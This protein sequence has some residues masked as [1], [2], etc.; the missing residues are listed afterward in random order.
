MKKIQ[1]K[2]LGGWLPENKELQ[3]KWVNDLLNIVNGTAKNASRETME[4]T[5]Q[6]RSAET[7]YVFKH[8]EVIDFLELI[9]TDPKL[10]LLAEQMIDQAL[11]YDE[12]DPT[13]SPQITSYNLMLRII[14]HII[15]TAPEYVP[16]EEKEKRALIGF[17]INA[18]LDWCMGTQAGYAFFLDERVNEHFEKILKA[19]C[20]YLSSKESAYVL[21]KN[22]ENGGWLCDKA[23]LELGMDQYQCD[24]SKDYY[25]FESWNDFF[26]RKFKPDSR[27]IAEADK[28]P[29]VI[30]NA[31]ESQPYKISTN[32]Q[33]DTKFWLKGQPYSLEYMLNHDESADLFVGGTVYQA[34]LSATRYHRWHSPVD[35]KVVRCFNVPGTYYAEVNTYP[36]DGA[37]PNNSQ[38]YITHVAARAVILIESDNK[39]IGLM[40]FIAV[41]MAEVS[42]C[43]IGVKEGQ[44]LNK[45]DELGYFQFGGSTHCLIFQKDVIDMFVHDAIPAEDFNNSSLIKLNSKLAVVKRKSADK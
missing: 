37:G 21:N 8:Q 12:N 29:Y 40:A 32:V 11:E 42:S 36:Y 43:V 31:C 27:P 44:H 34:F 9:D 19:W 25:G 1:N 23:L 35:G 45:G 26:T 38:G 17:P 6:K 4:N 30:T 22:E 20:K 39:D 5:V 24:P 13:G 41:G 18:I 14:D 15:S 7:P 28:D 33:K 2:R 16:P 10:H 3:V